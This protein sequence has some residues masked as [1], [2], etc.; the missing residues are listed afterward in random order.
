MNEAINKYSIDITAVFGIGVDVLNVSRSLKTISLDL[1]LLA[2]NGIVQAAKVSNNQGQSL[3]TLSG[4]L[5]SLPTQIAPELADLEYLSNQLAREITICSIV[6]RRFINYSLSLEKT[7]ISTLKEHNKTTSR[8]I[9][10]YSTK[11]L[12]NLRNN[13]I[14]SKLE[15]IRKENIFILADKNLDLINDMNEYLLRS[16]SIIIKARKKIERI[17]QNGLVANY[18]GTNIS[19]ESSYLLSGKKDFESLV[20]NIKIIVTTLNNK[21]DQILDKLIESEKLLSNLIKSGII[22]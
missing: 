17:R 8:N 6:V 12:Q 22:K 11:V 2:I 16:Q 19:I 20:N 4:F 3:I 14:L 1:K 10:I 15:P 9:N 21:L 7:I 5:S 13:N 18:M